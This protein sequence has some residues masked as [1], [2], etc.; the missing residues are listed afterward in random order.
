MARPNC[1]HCKYYFVTWDVRMP[2]GC[3]LFDIKTAQWP[4]DIVKASSGEDCID[5][6]EKKGPQKEADPFDFNDERFWRE[7]K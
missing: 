4:T 3:K 7:K 1:Y 6:E 2:R 5:F